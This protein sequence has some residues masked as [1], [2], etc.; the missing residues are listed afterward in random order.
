MVT[1]YTTEH[2][3]FLEDSD[4]HQFVVIQYHLHARADELRVSFKNAH[5]QESL[6]YLL[7]TVYIT[8]IFFIFEDS[9]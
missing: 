7:D 3:V 2:R 8:G 6:M 1:V 4:L 5:D 9:T